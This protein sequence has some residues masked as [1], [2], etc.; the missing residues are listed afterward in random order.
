MCKE[1][2]ADNN[3]TTPLLK[4]FD[5][6]KIIHNIFVVLVVVAF[7]FLKIQREDCNAGISPL[8]H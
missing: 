2:Y 1:C 3:R 7:V 4:P 6:L 5:C 8:S